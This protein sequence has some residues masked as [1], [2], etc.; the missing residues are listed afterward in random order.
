MSYLLCAGRIGVLLVLSVYCIDFVGGLKLYG[1]D[2]RCVWVCYWL[3]TVCVLVVCWL[4][5]GCLGLCICWFG[6]VMGVQWLLSCC[7]F[8]CV[9]VVYRLACVLCFAGVLV[10]VVQQ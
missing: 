3:F 6:C 5:M 4:C 1:L 7:V 2:R 10:V 8:C 9:L